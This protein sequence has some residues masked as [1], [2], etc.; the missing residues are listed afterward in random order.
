MS[1]SKDTIARYREA[2]RADLARW[3][4]LEA[5]A[6][7]GELEDW[8]LE[9]PELDDEA[10]VAGDVADE[11]EDL[12]PASSSRPRNPRKKSLDMRWPAAAVGAG[13]LIWL[14]SKVKGGV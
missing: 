9:P 8:E 5:R 12:E 6:G 14:A 11:D 1:K 10:D 2:A 13:V 7:N 3:E 4:R